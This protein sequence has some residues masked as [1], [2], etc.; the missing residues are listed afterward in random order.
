MNDVPRSNYIQAGIGACLVGIAFGCY[1]I[2]RGATGDVPRSELTGEQ[3]VPSWMYLAGGVAVLILAGGALVAM[4]WL[5]IVA[6]NE[7]AI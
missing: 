2:W 3:I 6:R 4:V 5:Y 1:L 7:Y